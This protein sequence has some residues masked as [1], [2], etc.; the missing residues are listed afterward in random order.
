[1]AIMFVDKEEIILVGEGEFT[2]S[3]IQ[4]RACIRMVDFVA[5][6]KMHR[7]HQNMWMWRTTELLE[8]IPNKGTKIEHGKEK[9]D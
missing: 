3:E 9:K 7:P 6:K 5:G 2:D 1:M 8:K 4:I